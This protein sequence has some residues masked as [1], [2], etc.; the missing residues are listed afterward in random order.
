MFKTIYPTKDATIYSHYPEKNTGVDEILELYKE[1]YGSPSLE[2]DDTVFYDA[3]YFSRILIQFDLTDISSSIVNGRINGNTQFFL[4]VK[5]TEV[6]DIPVTYTLYAYPVSGSWLNG[7]GFANS[8]PQVKNGVSWRYSDSKLSGTLWATSSLG[9]TVTASY[10]T[11]P[12]GGTWYTSSI[13]SQSFNFDSPDIRMNV[14]NIVNQWLSGS[15]ANNGFIIKYSDSVEQDSSVMGN[16]QF[17]SRESHTI[18]LPRLEVFWENTDLSGT[19]SFT[20]ISSEDFVLYT[21]NLRESYSEVE[22]PK[23]RIGV[24]E[25]YPTQTYSTS[26]IYTSTSR[27]PIASYFQV[28]D[29]VTDEVIV[30]FHVS[31]TQ[32]NCDSNGNYIKLDCNSLMPER[33]YKL[34][35]RSEFENGDTVRIVDENH[36]FKIIRN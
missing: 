8:N 36:M 33:Y 26:S 16:L 25:R 32:V 13:S 15:I 34:V 6:T 12:H 2:N 1:T 20:E 19:G 29:V 18:F 30:P 21:K 31:G 35:F 9:S 22:I 10:N 27:L 14:T 7:T 24:R 17:F 28:Q 4:T 11:I 3:T 5:T 23:V